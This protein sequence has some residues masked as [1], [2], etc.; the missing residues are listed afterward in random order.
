MSLPYSAMVVA[1]LLSQID[2][3]KEPHP[4]AIIETQT[5]SG[6][7]RGRSRFAHEADRG[8]ARD[9]STLRIS[10]VIRLEE[11]QP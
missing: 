4:V 11:S 9:V 1:P 2:D 3:R 7:F 6:V 5:W 10:Q 8:A